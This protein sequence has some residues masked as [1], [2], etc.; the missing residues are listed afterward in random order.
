MRERQLRNELMELSHRG[1]KRNSD[2]IIDPKIERLRKARGEERE[3]RQ[4]KMG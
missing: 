2:K 4:T 1:L 3:K